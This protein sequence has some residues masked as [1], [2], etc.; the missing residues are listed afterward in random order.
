MGTVVLAVNCVAAFF[1]DY[2]GNKVLVCQLLHKHAHGERTTS[3]QRAWQTNSLGWRFGATRSRGCWCC[4]W[5]RLRPR[6]TSLRWPTAASWTTG[7][8]TRHAA[9][10]STRATRSSATFALCATSTACC[11]SSTCGCTLWSRALSTTGSGP[12]TFPSSASGSSSPTLTCLPHSPHRTT[13]FALVVRSQQHD[14]QDC[15]AT[16]T[17]PEDHARGKPSCGGARGG[18]RQRAATPLAGAQPHCPGAPCAA[19][20]A[21]AAATETRP[22]GHRRHRMTTAQAHCLVAH[23]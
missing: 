21:E 9:R 15:A 3:D 6:S 2:K 5:P 13:R 20:A 14:K 19:D 22:A 7:G 23:R 12:S 18:G 16:T 8:G 4:L 17:E 11:A 1:Y 10:R